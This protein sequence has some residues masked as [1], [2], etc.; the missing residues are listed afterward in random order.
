MPSKTF[1]LEVLIII[2]ISFL[3]LASDIAYA[4]KCGG[5][6]PAGAFS[7]SEIAFEGR[8]ESVWPK[9]LLEKGIPYDGIALAQTYKFRVFRKWKGEIQGDSIVLFLVGRGCDPFFTQGETYLVYAYR[10]KDI[11]N[12]LTSS[13]CI[14]TKPSSESIEDFEFLGPGEIVSDLTAKYVPEAKTR[15][16]YR[17]LT[18]YL[19]TGKYLWSSSSTWYPGFLY[20]GSSF[21]RLAPYPVFFLH[22]ILLTILWFSLHISIHKKVSPIFLLSSVCLILSVFTM[23]MK[24]DYWFVGFWLNLLFLFLFSIFQFIKMKF[25][26]AIGLLL[27][28]I[29]FFLVGLFVLLYLILNNPVYGGFGYLF[30]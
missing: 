5:A 23:T 2:L 6:T 28:C 19:L 16:I 14:R 29:C 22:L 24:L 8:A 13:V 25:K 17:H 21:I 7:R 30:A 9:L 12:R 4:C 11:N 20:V 27:L 18:I 1:K 26:L 10:S 15:R 3:F